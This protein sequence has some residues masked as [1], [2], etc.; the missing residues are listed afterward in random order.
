MSEQPATYL[1]E[2]PH[3]PYS[4]S[5]LPYLEACQGWIGDGTTSPLAARGTAIGELL[6]QYMVGG[7]DPLDG[8]DD[9]D[10]DALAYGLLALDNIRENYPDL[11]WESEPFVATGIDGCGGYLDLLGPDAWLG[12][13]VL[14]E[15]KTG[16]GERAPAADNRQVQ[17]YALGVLHTYPGIDR[18]TAYLVEC[19]RETTTTAVFTS[20]DMPRLRS[21]V[22]VLILHAKCATDASLTP[23]PQCRY[24]AR[25]EQC[26]RLVEAP[27]LA[28]AL[29]GPRHLS[30]QDYAEALSPGALGETLARVAPLA[31][32]VESYI[33]ALKARCMQIL[34]A[35]GEVPGWGV[36]ASNGYRT[37]ADEAGVAAAIQE[38]DLDLGACMAMVSPAQVEKALGKPAKALIAPYT[39]QGK[40]RSLVQV[41]TPTTKAKAGAPI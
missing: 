3:E 19:D 14:V 40:R 38:A 17:A 13:A 33:G 30:P 15:I 6:A 31:D 23:G 7:T 41:R 28:L 20:A 35:G 4:P 34:E 26:P 29:I 2:R 37:W 8:A 36:K 10:R 39:Q 24:C 18:V 5:R 16:R 9:A 21:M 12:E 25:R 22:R 32:L 1:A 11:A 27:D